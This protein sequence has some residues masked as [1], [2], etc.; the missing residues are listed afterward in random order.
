MLVDGLPVP[1]RLIT[2]I[3]R[4]LWPSTAAEAQW[5]NI[6]SLVPAERIHLFAPEE[7][8]I[9]LM[10]PP[11][12]TVATIRQSQGK[13]KFWD[14]FAHLKAYHLNCR[15][16]SVTLDLARILRLCSTIER[17]ATVQP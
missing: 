7:D 9:Y 13:G 12:R 1:H 4:G 6:H 15:S 16:T 11:F 14:R 2:L 17:T 8:K 5:Q 3:D 10:A